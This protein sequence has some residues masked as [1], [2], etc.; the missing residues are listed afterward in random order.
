MAHST[1]AGR[2]ATLK[3]VVS[4]VRQARPRDRIIDLT[5]RS[6]NGRTAA[7]GAVNRGSNPCRGATHFKIY[8]K[9]AQQSVV[10]GLAQIFVQNT[11]NVTANPRHLVHHQT[12]FRRSQGPGN[13]PR[14]ANGAHPRRRPRLELASQRGFRE[15][16]QHRESAPA[17]P[18][19]VDGAGF[20]DPLG[21]SGGLSEW[22]EPLREPNRSRFS[23]LQRYRAEGGVGSRTGASPPSRQTCCAAANPQLIDGKSLISNYTFWTGA[24]YCTAK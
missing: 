8:S 10:L 17:K 20:F 6:S 2:D 13:R 19:N 23:G 1:L 11:G 16:S 9:D 21:R 4:A 3:G 18:G 24:N 14:S 15:R 22:S 5:P 7:F 12:P